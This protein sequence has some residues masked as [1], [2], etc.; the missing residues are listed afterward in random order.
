MTLD[1]KGQVQIYLNSVITAS[2]ANSFLFLWM[3]KVSGHRYEQAVKGQGQ[4][5]LKSSYG[6]YANPSLFF[7]IRWFIFRNND[8]LWYV[9]YVFDRQ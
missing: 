1:S 4:I 8:W 7:L 5:Y 6:T 2:N 9:Y 3:A